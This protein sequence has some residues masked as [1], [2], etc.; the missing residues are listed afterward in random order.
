MTRRGHLRLAS[1]AAASLLALGGTSACSEDSSRPAGPE[2]TEVFLSEAATPDAEDGLPPDFPRDAV[3]VLTG[4]VASS[5]GDAEAGFSVTTNIYSAEAEP[6]LDQAITLLEEAGW[7]LSDRTK[8]LGIPSA[9]LS[10]PAGG[11][12][13]LQA[14][15]S[16]DDVT[17]TY[18][19]RVDS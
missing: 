13:I 6:V 8:E 4:E 1:I 9:S 15:P 19:A 2:P 11:L 5:D 18:F 17:L 12:V 3:P 14:V 10:L 7:Q 16:E